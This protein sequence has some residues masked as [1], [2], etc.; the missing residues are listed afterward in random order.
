MVDAHDYGAA[1]DGKADDTEALRHALQSGDGILDLRKGT[2]RITRPLIVDL[3]RTGYAS[4]RGAGGAARILM[5]G[6][7]PAIR[8][9]G[10]HQGTSSPGT[11]K[12]PIWERERFPTIDG[13]E[14]VGK[15]PQAVGI[16]LRKTMQA[17]ISRVLVRDCR[18][19][20]HLVERNRNFVLTDSHLYDNAEYGL[21]FDRCNLHQIN[22]HG[23]HIGF[24]KRAG[25]KS[26]DGDVHNLQITGNDIEYNNDPGRKQ[27]A[28]NE[29]T[30]AE[31]WFEANNGIISEVTIASNTIQATVQPGGANIR[32]HGPLEDSPTGARLIAITGNIIGSQT[33]GIE[34]KHAHRVAISGNTIYDSAELSLAAAHCSAIAVGANTVAW[35]NLDTR[36]PRDGFLFEECDNCALTGLVTHKLGYGNHAQGGAITLRRCTDMA[37]T[38][39]QLTD[40]RVRGIDLID[41]SRCRISDNSI[42]DRRSHPMMRDAIRLT[43]RGR[44]NVV[45]HNLIGGSTGH[46]LDVPS[47]QAT[48]S[49]NVE[50]NH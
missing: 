4:I 1:G 45:Q 47:N 44:D 3:K 48:L 14:I 11:V 33:R 50:I 28:E 21:F 9:V 2:Y 5:T 39:C 23:N 6:A 34:L 36:P 40:P 30:G 31:I 35:K 24:N 17:T 29:P 25:I 27:P 46:N 20:I 38:G 43:G 12:S 37:V 16:E 42:V 7:G 41:C 15:H 32:I 10:S 13:I 49:G 18:H 19:G 26:L 8:L 22:V